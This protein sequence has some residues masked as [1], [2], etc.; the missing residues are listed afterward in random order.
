MFLYKS[1]FSTILFLSAKSYILR[2]YLWNIKSFKWKKNIY[3]FLIFNFLNA[4][5]DDSSLL[6]DE[7][8]FVIPLPRVR[9]RGRRSTISIFA[10]GTFN[11]ILLAKLQIPLKNSDIHFIGTHI[12]N[13]NYVQFSTVWCNLMGTAFEEMLSWTA[14]TWYTVLKTAFKTKIGKS[15]SLGIFTIKIWNFKSDWG[16]CIFKELQHIT[17]RNS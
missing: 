4:P 12:K 6:I 3:I 11:F 1:R 14:L 15:E 7:M 5:M 8:L 16:I 13:E 2:I 10:P 9:V 17:T